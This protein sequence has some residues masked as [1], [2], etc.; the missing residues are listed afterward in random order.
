MPILFLT[1][2]DHARLSACPDAVAQDDP[3]TYFQLNAEDLSIIGNLKGESNRL[4][5]AL[6]LCCLRY[7]GFVPTNLVLLDSS[8]VGYVAEQLSLS[9]AALADYGS[10][11][12][13]L[14]DHQQQ[15]LAH[16]SYRRATPL[17]LLTLAARARPGARPAQ[18]HLRPGLRLPTP[19]THRPAWYDAPCQAGGPG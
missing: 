10:R 16:L 4:G 17:D 2:A 12:P 3:D 7:L 18:A 14:H 1:D 15:V 6:Q 13:T 5:F 19:G 8:I 9:P 11:E